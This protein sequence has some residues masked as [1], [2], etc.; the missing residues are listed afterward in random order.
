MA[1]ELAKHL[2]EVKLQAAESKYALE[3]QINVLTTKVEELVA[4]S[5]HRIQELSHSQNQIEQLKVE[6]STK[7]RMEERFVLKFRI[8]N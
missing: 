7:Y 6:N 2:A 8:C 3:Q 5:E 4:E 1:E